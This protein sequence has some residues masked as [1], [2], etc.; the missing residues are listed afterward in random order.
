MERGTGNLLRRL[1]R[2]VGR[3]RLRHFVMVGDNYCV[4]GVWNCDGV[5]DMISSTEGGKSHH[6][7]PFR[8]LFFP[9]LPSFLFSLW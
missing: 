1:I 6:P 3:G 7:A 5:F 2:W 8:S 9:L 4:Y